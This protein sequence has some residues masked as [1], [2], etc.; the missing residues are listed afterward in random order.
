MQAS[1]SHWIERAAASPD[2]PGWHTRGPRAAVQGLKHTDAVPASARLGP[3]LPIALRLGENC[4]F[5]KAV[6]AIEGN[7]AC[8]C[9]CARTRTHTHRRHG[10]KGPRVGTPYSEMLTL[11]L[12]APP[13]LP[14]A[15]GEGRLGCLRPACPACPARRER[16]WTEDAR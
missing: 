6:P 13:Q 4:V 9:V 3:Q 16:T 2:P 8:A 11:D 1:L 10:M 15:G 14:G 5:Q 12:A 7:A